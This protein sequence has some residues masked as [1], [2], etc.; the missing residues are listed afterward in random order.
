MPKANAWTLNPPQVNPDSQNDFG[1]YNCTA[2]NE[3]GTESK[4]FILIQAGPSVLC[5]MT[6]TYNFCVFPKGSLTGCKLF[7]HLFFFSFTDRLHFCFCISEHWVIH[8]IFLECT[9]LEC[10][11]ALFCFWHVDVPSAP[12]IAQVEPYSST[13]EVLFDEPEASGGVP[14]LKYRAEW[15]TAGRNWAQRVY[16]ARD[17]TSSARHI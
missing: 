17:G 10:R 11:R 1:S 3:I 13:A 6:F 14:V 2:S 4:E 9:W 8:T 15:R 7:H 12:T 16:E 5:D